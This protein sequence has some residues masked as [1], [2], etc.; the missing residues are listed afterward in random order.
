MPTD[1][2]TDSIAAPG[3]NCDLI[4]A[5]SAFSLMFLGLGI[6]FTASNIMAQANYGDPFYFI[7][8]Q[9]MPLFP[10]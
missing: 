5:A 9:G 2:N 4:L 1:A 6:I 7:K 8:R 3:A 10:K